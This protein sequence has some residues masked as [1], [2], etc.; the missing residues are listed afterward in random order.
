MSVIDNALQSL[1]SMSRWE[2][3]WQNAS[4]ESS[5]AAQTISCGASEYNNLRCLC[6]T[7]G[8]LFVDVTLHDGNRAY[9]QTIANMSGSSSPLFRS[10]P[11]DVSGDSVEFGDSIWKQGTSPGTSNDTLIPVAI[12]GNKQK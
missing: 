5:F 2:I 11:I 7:P 3:L 8:G 12:L 9:A 1:F 4:P 10:R 6:A